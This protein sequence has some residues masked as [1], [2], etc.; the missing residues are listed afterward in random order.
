[1]FTNIQTLLTKPFL[2]WVAHRHQKHLQNPENHQRR[3]LKT[4]IK[5]AKNTNFGQ[6]HNFSTIKNYTD[7]KK[8]VPIRTYEEFIPYINA[9]RAGT[10][11]VLWP[12][13]PAYWATTAGTTAGSKYIPISRASLPHHIRS[14][15]NALF[16]YA[17]R[18]DNATLLARHM[19][20][21]SGNSRLSM[22]SQVPTG[23]LSG[24]VNYHVPTYV[25]HQHLP[26]HD[27][28]CIEN[29]EEKID[30]IVTETLTY[31]KHI[32]LIAGIPPW[33]QMYFDKLQERT[34]QQIKDI[35]PHFSLLVHGGVNFSPYR[36]KLFDT[37]GQAVDTLE[38]Y[39]ASEG[40][41]AWQDQTPDLGLLLQLHQD[42]FFEFVPT[43]TYFT[44]S[45]T[46]LWIDEVETGVDYALII[47]S[48][49]G[50]WAYAI[51]DTVRF[52]SLNPYRIVVTGR[53]QHFISAFG[54]HVIVE[55]VEKALESTLERYTEVRVTEFTVAPFVSTT[56]GTPSCHE[57]LIE[58]SQAPENMDAF[59]SELDRQ[60]CGLN[61]Y[62]ADLIRGRVL[63]Q[64]RIVPLQA[65]VFYGYRKKEN[66]L[67][68][69]NKVVR[70]AN[71]RKLA[72]KLLRLR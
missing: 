10:D 29:W 24:I 72:D 38:T 68:E 4:L 27:T 51:G 37:I 69:Q 3:I 2:H 11:N 15:R 30:Q 53:V 18:T 43:S 48:S 13:Q 44:A 41:I 46:R 28:N 61:P 39:P 70:L 67:G 8:N 5:K 20:F 33:L 59:A 42:I 12:G 17:T 21:L 9:I 50:L 23:R 19:L 34:G 35:L 49:A 25:S 71:D 14:A 56:A 65:G 64:L 55:E 22:T 58:F 16:H 7:F 62:Y 1:M 63:G 6:I 26:S 31:R 47:S 32:G 66:R 54:E 36:Q 57:W 45:P 52:T 40:F 60:M